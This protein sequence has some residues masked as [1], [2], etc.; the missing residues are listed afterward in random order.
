ME[1]PG[2]LLSRA[3]EITTLV[4]S[5]GKRQSSVAGGPVS[6]CRPPCARLHTR[7]DLYEGLPADVSRPSRLPESRRI[8]GGFARTRVEMSWASG[9]GFAE[10]SCKMRKMIEHLRNSRIFE[11]RRKR[12]KTIKDYRKL[13]EYL[14]WGGPV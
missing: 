2:K 9:R 8:Q 1:I 10:R 6:A 12:S 11:F 3:R 13:P 4:A 5:F 14:D 7:R